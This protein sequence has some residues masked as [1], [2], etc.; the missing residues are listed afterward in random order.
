MMLFRFLTLEAEGAGGTNEHNLCY[1]SCLILSDTPD[2]FHLCLSMSAPLIRV[3]PEH[4]Q[5]NLS[6]VG[7]VGEGQRIC[8]HSIWTCRL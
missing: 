2:V 5:I 1:F 8:L 6:V 7:P 3:H 4:D